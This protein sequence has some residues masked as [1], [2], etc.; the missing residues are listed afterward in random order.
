MDYRIV[1]ISTDEEENSTEA[2]VL[3]RAYRAAWRATYGAEPSGRHEFA[4]LNLAMRFGTGNESRGSW[5]LK[6][7]FTSTDRASDDEESHAD[8][9]TRLR[10]LL[11]S[12]TKLEE[13]SQILA[14]L[15]SL[16]VT[17]HRWSL[18]KRNDDPRPGEQS[19]N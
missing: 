2:H 19:G 6:S 9:W 10:S 11:D 12:G 3:A 7:P 4:S 18:D 14:A 8:I 15:R 1:N 17:R 13:L 5:S 16:Q